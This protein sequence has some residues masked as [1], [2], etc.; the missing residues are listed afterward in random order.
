MINN[1]KLDKLLLVKKRG[2]F[3][4]ILHK[5]K[6]YK[7]DLFIIAVR[8]GKELRFGFTA[9]S[10]LKKVTRNRLKRI[11]R[12]LWRRHYKQFALSGEWIIMA[13]EK[14]GHCDPLLRDSRFLKLMRLIETDLHKN[15]AI[16]VK[17]PEFT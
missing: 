9:K 5:G 17:P 7:S 14:S 2:D 16:P 8:K 15:T 3:A 12:E 1:N 4:D 10:G 6:I 13:R 11:S